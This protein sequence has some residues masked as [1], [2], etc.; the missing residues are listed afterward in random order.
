MSVINDIKGCKVK[1]RIYIITYRC[2]YEKTYSG[3]L[4]SNEM[5]AFAYFTC[6]NLLTNNKSNIT[7][8]YKI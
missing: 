7:I 6:V 2:I 3:Y 8:T 1:K 4:S 5:A